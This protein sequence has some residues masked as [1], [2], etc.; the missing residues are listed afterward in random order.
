MR[1]IA[2]VVLVCMLAA[3][4]GAF[5]ARNGLALGAEAVSS[6]FNSWGG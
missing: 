3:S 2:V 5:A 4:T 6:N 1:K